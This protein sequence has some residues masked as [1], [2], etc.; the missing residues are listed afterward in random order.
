MRIKD[1]CSAAAILLILALPLSAGAQTAI[2]TSVSGCDFVG[3]RVTAGCVPAFLAHI[4]RFIFGLTG[5]F[6][7]IMIIISGYQIALAKA[8]GRDRSEGFTRLRVAIIGFILCA[9][10]WFIIDF[11]IRSL[12]FGY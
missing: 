5:A 6:A 12:A 1:S 11:I 9:F 3:G 8:L 7:L 2:V 4:I 10:S